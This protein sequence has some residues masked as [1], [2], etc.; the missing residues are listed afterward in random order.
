M[1]GLK[2]LA[3]A[4]DDGL[5]APSST[6]HGEVLTNIW[7]SQVSLWLTLKGQQCSEKNTSDWP[8]RLPAKP[9]DGSPLIEL[10]WRQEMATDPATKRLLAVF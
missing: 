6:N 3:P 7:I 8:A 4:V 9:D 2:S 5:G 1:F 10:Q